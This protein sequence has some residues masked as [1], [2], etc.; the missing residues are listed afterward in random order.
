LQK[1]EIE[2]GAT[3]L[4]VYLDNCS[5]TKT[6]INVSATKVLTIEDIKAALVEV[7]DYY[8]SSKLIC[9]DI[10]V[11]SFSLINMSFFYL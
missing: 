6:C 10:T 8:D 7:H 5:S 9:M 3:K 2:N 4:I 11:S 1:I